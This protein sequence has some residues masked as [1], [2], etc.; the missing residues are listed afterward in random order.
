MFLNNF[1][2]FTACGSVEKARI[3]YVEITDI[4]HVKNVAC[5]SNMRKKFHRMFVRVDAYH[6][7]LLAF[8]RRV[9]I[10]VVSLFSC[11]SHVNFN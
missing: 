2:L 4:E 9:N 3:S 8:T 7:E 10:P 6:W 11:A 1:L 5:R